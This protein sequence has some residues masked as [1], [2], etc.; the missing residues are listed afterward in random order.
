[1]FKQC[2]VQRGPSLMIVTLPAKYVIKGKFL[3]IMDSDGWQVK[4]VYEEPI[5]EKLS[6]TYQNNYK[7]TDI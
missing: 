2:L 4:E 3:K 1:M 7:A 5:G 6:V